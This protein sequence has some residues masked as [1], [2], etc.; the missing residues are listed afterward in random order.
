MFREKIFLRGKNRKKRV[1]KMINS[2]RVVLKMH[3][4]GYRDKFIEAPPGTRDYSGQET[5]TMNG[6]VNV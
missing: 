2:V 4:K 1:S 6:L 3:E 5:T